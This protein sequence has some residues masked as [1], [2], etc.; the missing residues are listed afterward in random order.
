MIFIQAGKAHTDN[1]CQ[2]KKRQSPYPV[3]IQRKRDSYGQET[4]F[5]HMCSL[6]D[7]V[8]DLFSFIC[9]FIITFVCI[10]KLVFRF[11]D[12]IADLVA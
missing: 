6:P 10:E 12:L 1:P 11:H 7:I 8:M 3:Y 9:Q 2:K 4:V 5:C